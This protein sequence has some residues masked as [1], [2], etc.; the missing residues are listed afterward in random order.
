MPASSSNAAQNATLRP[1][2][3]IR[4]ADFSA[5]LAGPY[6]AMILAQ[7]GADVI[8]VEPPQGD[9]ARSWPPSVDGLSLTHRYVGAGCRQ[10][11]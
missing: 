8:K 10:C 7:L 4:V 11:T 2:A 5:N 3:G 9:D 1:L 6:G